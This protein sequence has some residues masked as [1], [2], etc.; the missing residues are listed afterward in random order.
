V[1][2]WGAGATQ[3]LG[4]P[5]TNVQAET[6]TKLAAGGQALRGRV[7]RAFDDEDA[8]G[9]ERIA[10][11]LEILGDMEADAGGP[12]PDEASWKA[13]LAR[14]FPRLLDEKRQARGL[15]LRQTYDWASLRH[16]IRTCPRQLVEDGE[17]RIDLRDLF[18]LI[19]LHLASA[20][21]FHIPSP[22]GPGD[23]TFVRPARL[24]GARNCLQMLIGLQ[25]FLAYHR[26]RQAPEKLGPYEAFCREL[27]EWMQEEGCQRASEG[28]DLADRRFYLYSHAIISMN[29][30]PMLLWLLFNAQR[31]ANER[32]PLIGRPSLPMRLFH[33]LG[34]VSAM[35]RIDGEHPGIWYPMNEAIAQRLNDEEHDTG[36]RVRLGKFYFPHGTL[37]GR[38]CPSCGKYFLHFGNHWDPLSE[39]LLPAPLLPDWS[40]G[41]ADL[42]GEEGRWHEQGRPEGL[43]C[44]YCAALV[45]LERVRLVMQTGFHTVLPPALE[46]IQ[47]DMRPAL[48]NAEHLVFMGYS[49]PAD[50]LVYRSLLAARRGQAERPR[51]CTVVLGRDEMAATHFLEP[52]DLDEYL[53]RGSGESPLAKLIQSV[54]VIF[55]ANVNV[56]AYARGIPDVFIDPASGAV[57]SERVRGLLEW[58]GS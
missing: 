28:H 44:P 37:N 22:G 32:A 50:D 47:R 10:D 34:Q 3:A 53:N 43:Q 18:N 41:W 8:A 29:W 13:A 19:D 57:T 7:E 36:R 25:F 40:E 23:A 48:E 6:L 30:D 31:E 14:Q 12:R 17:G 11:L 4:F 27:A 9:Q 2:F 35:R 42:R 24:P 26:L 1:V 46:E 49:M 33:D 15:E 39:N 16:L 52:P 38:E 51:R 21:G 54:K 56:R 55:G 45:D 58:P 20:H 5:T